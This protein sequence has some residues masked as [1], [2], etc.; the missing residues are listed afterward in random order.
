MNLELQNIL[1]FNE[2]SLKVHSQIIKNTL[3]NLEIVNFGKGKN[4]YPYVFTPFTDVSGIKLGQPNIIDSSVRLWIFHLFNNYLTFSPEGDI[5]IIKNGKLV[6]DSIGKIIIMSEADRGGGLLAYK[7]AEILNLPL[8]LTTIYHEKAVEDSKG[9]LVNAE[10]KPD[11]IVGGRMTNAFVNPSLKGYK[12][13]IFIDEMLS[14]GKT[15]KGICNGLNRAKLKP[16]ACYVSAEKL[17]G[18]RDLLKKERLNVPVISLC[19][20]TTNKCAKVKLIQPN[21]IFFLS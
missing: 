21:K 13:Y 12:Y 9:H 1:S 17:R 8:F 16:I 2:T 10:S 18:G 19:K 7:M 6:Q 11:F 20:F 15:I 5:C 14:G 4:T 3:N